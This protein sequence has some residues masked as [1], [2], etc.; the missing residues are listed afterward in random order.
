MAKTSEEWKQLAE[1][2]AEQYERHPFLFKR[3]VSLLISLGY[4]VLTLVVVLNVL[5]IAALVWWHLKNGFSFYILAGYV[6]LG[7]FLLAAIK[8]LLLRLPPP[9]GLSI[10]RSD[11]PYLFEMIDSLRKPMKLRSKEVHVLVD[12]N[13]NAFAASYPMF[14]WF[15]PSRLFVC[16]GLP[17]VASLHQ[18]E[19]KAVIAHEVAHLSRKHGR[20]TGR[21]IRVMVVWEALILRLKNR[22]ILGAP[23]RFFAERYFQYLSSAL[24]VFQRS[25]E[26]EAD[27]L[28]AEAVSK[29]AI[30]RSLLRMSLRS[31]LVVEEYWNFLWRKAPTVD[32]PPVKAV[33]RLFARLGEPVENAEASREMRFL[34]GDIT[35]AWDEHPCLIDRIQALEVSLP[36]SHEKIPAFVSEWRLGSPA[37]C[38]KNVFRGKDLEVGREIDEIWRIVN[39]AGWIMHHASLQPITRLMRKL[40]TEWKTKGRLNADK[41]WRYAELTIGFHGTK[42][43]VRALEYVLEQKP[44]HHH[45]NFYLG[46]H[47]LREFDESGFERVEKAIEQDPLSYR[48][49]GLFLISDFQRRFGRIEESRETESRSFEANDKLTLALGER[50]K[51]IRFWNSFEPHGIEADDLQELEEAFADVPGISKVYLVRKSVQHMPGSPLYVFLLKPTLRGWASLRTVETELIEGVWFSRDHRT[52]PLSLWRR[53]LWLRMRFVSGSLVYRKKWGLPWSRKRKPPAALEKSG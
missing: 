38:L 13:Y 29:D 39:A 21:V 28:A 17:L 50:A 19:L 18:E 23:F 44:D 25:S 8:S 34:L 49:D 32:M 9:P 36:G 33:S 12:W 6:G 14:G 16:V 5:L 52:F 41:A 45:A 40:E 1:S 2:Y 26:Y 35:R 15:G 53:L 46:S 20:F 22:S 47:L 37:S 43:A 48:R 51:P 3:K 4:A 7:L 24:A 10:E 31:N 11:F 42:R 27:R 30:A